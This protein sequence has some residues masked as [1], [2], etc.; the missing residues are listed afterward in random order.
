MTSHP[1]GMSA[2]PLS[3]VS[4]ANLLR[5]HSISLSKSLMK[6]LNSTGPSTGPRPEGHHVSL[7]ILCILFLENSVNE[8]ALAT[9]RHLNKFIL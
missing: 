5:V 9:V 7:N 6:M 1:S 3:L 2:A 8:N 4:S